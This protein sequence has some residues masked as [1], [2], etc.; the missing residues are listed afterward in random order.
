MKIY[1]KETL[2][3][4]T[5]FEEQKNQSEHGIFTAARVSAENKNNYLLLVPGLGEITAECTGKLMF[6]VD[7]GTELPKTGDWVSVQLFPD[8]LKGVIHTVYKRQT[9][10]G[11][12]VA[13][14]RTEEQI[15]A[16]NID[17]VFLVQGLDNNF[18]INRLFRTV[19]MVQEASIQPVI[20]LNKADIANDADAKLKLVQ[21]QLKEVPVIMLSALQKTGIEQ[22][23]SYIKEGESIVF[24]G[25]SGAGKSTLINALSETNMALTGA[26]R[27]QDDRGK[28]TTTRREMFLLPEGGILID[29]PGMRE[30]QLYS[31]S[32]GLESTFADITE[33]ADSCRYR[34]CTHTVEKGCAVLDALEEGDISEAQYDNFLKLQREDAYMKTRTDQKAFLEKKAKDKQ[35]HKMIKNMNKKRKY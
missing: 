3:W 2:G 11:R 16:T 31:A 21:E 28:H 25:S 8:E 29:T 19:V 5:F 35:L 18:N 6:S 4:N 12:K 27:S 10:L 23:K 14:K 26:V 34:D 1:S 13:G 7:N 24:M 9:S 15:I 33:L 22:L 30:F 20:V 32:Q 17:I